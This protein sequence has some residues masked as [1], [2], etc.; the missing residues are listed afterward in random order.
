MTDQPEYHDITLP[1]DT[2]TAVVHGV[3]IAI[4]LA[5]DQLVGQLIIAVDD[6]YYRFLLGDESFGSLLAQCVKFNDLQADP[7]SFAAAV[8]NLREGGHQ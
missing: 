6:G 7:S 4:A 2:I 8:D 1:V 3:A 5:D